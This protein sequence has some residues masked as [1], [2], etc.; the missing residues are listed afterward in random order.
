MV[1]DDGRNYLKHTRKKFDIIS[2]EIGQPFRQGLASFYTNDFYRQA[3]TA[4]S[5][6][7]LFCQFMPLIFFDAQQYKSLIATFTSVFPR[8]ILWYNYY[9]CIMVGFT[10]TSCSIDRNR[11]NEVTAIPKVKEDLDYSYW[12]GSRYSLKSFDIF[13]SSVLL[14]PPDLVRCGKN[15]RLFTDDKPV[16]EFE[17]AQHQ[18]YSAVSIKDILDTLRTY[19]GNPWSLVKNTFD[20]P[21]S[22]QE[23]R[24]IQ[25]LNLNNILALELFEKYSESNND[26]LSL[27]QAYNLNPKNLSIIYA[28]AGY[29]ADSNRYDS[30]ITYTT[31]I[32]ENNP[33]DIN[34]YKYLAEAYRVTNNPEKAHALILKADSLTRYSPGNR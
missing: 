22:A 30:A 33:E 21:I 28:L 18:R 1:V 3:K 6:G 5:P 14:G 19:R 26:I 23:V 4:L 9:E 34:A 2:V 25:D 13:I 24:T 10:D 32:I 8:S 15:G 17:T 16:L 29:Y 31:L 11:F 7:G 27:R 12:G 20:C